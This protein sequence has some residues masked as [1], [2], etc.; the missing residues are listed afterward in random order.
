LQISQ[1]F[2]IFKVYCFIRHPGESRGPEKA[3]EKAYSWI[4]A[5]SMPE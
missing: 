4:P 3:F 2:V 1:F 5:S